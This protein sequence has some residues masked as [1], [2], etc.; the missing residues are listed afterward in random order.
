MAKRK[1]YGD[2]LDRLKD[3]LLGSL[4][5]LPVDVRSGIIEGRILEDPLNA[6]VV[7]VRANATS[8]NDDQI[9][10]LKA[11]GL[12]EDEIFEATVCA[13]FVAGL[14]RYEVAMKALKESADEA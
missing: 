12:T 5:T 11:S 13:A 8:I 6:F 4:G 7:R 3:T 10:E 14:E 9:A 2:F 1:S